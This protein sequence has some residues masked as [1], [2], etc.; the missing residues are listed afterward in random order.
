MK[1]ITLLLGI[2]VTF[3][4]SSAS[5]GEW[6]FI[7]DDGEGDS[8][9]DEDDG[10]KYYY[11][12]DRVRKSGKYLYYWELKSF[13]N[14]SGGTLSFTTYIELDCSI[15]RYKTLKLQTYN[16]H[17]GKGKQLRDCNYDN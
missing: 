7:V 4:F 6:I 2:I 17:M 3:L 8:Y 12:K 5:W 14:H 13:P 9:S 15:F 10:G 1:K 16:S 11:D